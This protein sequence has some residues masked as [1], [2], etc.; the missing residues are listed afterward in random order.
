MRKVLA[1]LAA[2]LPAG[3]LA[4]GAMAAT[5]VASGAYDNTLMIGV[6]PTTGT[7]TGYFDMTQDGPPVMSCIFF[8]KGKLAGGSVD[9]FYSAEPKTDLIKGQLTGRGGGV[10]RLAL[11]QDHGGCGNVWSFADKDN[12]ADFTLQKTYPWTGV[13]V[14][15][16]DKAYF[17]PSAGAATHGKAYIIIDDG[18]GVLATKPGWVQAQFVGGTKPI[19]GWLKDSDLYAVP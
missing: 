11:P 12:P 19:T 1:L 7:V 6:D 13:R 16:T 3:M 5:P 2:V 15:K 14:V 8:L 9:T 4:A 18:V 17:Y 10:V